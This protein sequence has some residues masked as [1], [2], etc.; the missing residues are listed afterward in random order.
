MADNNDENRLIAERRQKLAEIRSRGE[1]FPNDFRRTAVAGELH[2]AYAGRAAESLTADEVEVAVAGR[3]LAKRVM[4]KT[5]FVK[6]QDRTGQIQLMVTRD[7]IGEERYAELKKWDLGDIVGARGSL[8]KTKTGELSVATSEL[9]LLVK[10]LRP[11]PEKW[12]G[13]ADQEIRL[14]QRYL[15]L[16]VSE[17]TRRVFELRAQTIAFVRQFLSALDFVEVETPMMHPIPGGATARP[18]ET[19]HNA[20]DKT[21]FLRIAPELYLK[22]LVVGGLERVFE[23]NRVFRN[24]GLSTR[25]N[26][27]FTI[28][29]VYQAYA[30]YEDLMALTERLLREA[31]RTVLGS[32]SV[33]YQGRRFDLEQPFGRVD[34]EQSVIDAVESLRREN[35]RDR[36]ALAAECRSR[37]IP[38]TDEYGA[39]KLVL[40]LFEKVVEPTLSGPLFV[41]HYPAEVSP[42]ARRTSSDPYLTDRFELFVDGREIANGFSELND[43]EDQAERFRAQVAAHA[44]GDKEAMRFDEDYVTALEYGLPPTG[45][46]GIGIDRVVM[47]LTDSASIRDVLLFPQLR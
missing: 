27:E 12:H 34:L 35:I 8:M 13:I 4:G 39:G 15:D 7:A 25:H 45:G 14:R 41:T 19:Y 11:M 5:S 3:M 6:L 17:E 43:P 1:A 46:L 24:E 21:L 29:E 47:L 18:F 33:E 10:S 44:D 2:A 37:D 36:D 28:L 42:L 31:A 40:E 32:A 26:P 30:T 23:L 20:L 22:R 38:V 9:R 16:I